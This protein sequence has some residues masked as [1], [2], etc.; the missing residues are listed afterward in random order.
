MLFANA[1]NR[2]TG[3]KEIPYANLG[4]SVAQRLIDNIHR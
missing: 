2:L 3:A 1:D 4:V